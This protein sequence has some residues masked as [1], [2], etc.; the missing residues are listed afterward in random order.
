M[1]A[2]LGG[3]F[4]AEDTKPEARAEFVAVEGREGKRLGQALHGVQGFHGVGLWR[5]NGNKKTCVGV[6]GH[7]GGLKVEN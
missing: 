2:L 6:G 5:V 4:A 1:L 3:N 7:D